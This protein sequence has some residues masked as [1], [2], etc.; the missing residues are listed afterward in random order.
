LFINHPDSLYN[1][2][3]IENP[4]IGAK[5]FH[6]LEYNSPTNDL[7]PAKKDPSA[8]RVFVMGSSTVVGFP[9]ESNLMFPR[10]LQK[11]LQEA[12]PAK[13][14]EVIN[15]AITAINSFTLQDFIDDILD[16]KPDAILIYAGHNEYYGAMG[17]GSNEG[18]GSNRG[19]IKL[20]LKLMDFR[21][22]QLIR[23]TIGKFTKADVI[24]GENK[25][26]TLMSRIVRNAEIAYGSDDYS[27]GLK[28]YKKNMTSILEKASDKK[29]PVFIST[30]VSNITDIKPFGSV[31]SETGES[32]EDIYFRAQSAR[33]Q[34]D[35]KLAKE[36][37]TRAK[38]LDCVRFRASS[39]INTAIEEMAQK[40][41]AILVPMLKAFEDKSPN[42][43]V[44]NNLLTE[45]VHPNVSGYFLMADVFYK[46][47]AESKLI[48][49]EPDRLTSHS[50][51]AFRKAYGF[52]HLDSLIGHHR[53][54]N[55][56]Y[57]WPYKDDSKNY[58]DYR[59]VYRPRNIMDSLAFS[60]MADKNLSGLE[61]HIT[62]ARKHIAQSWLLGAYHEYKAIV[63]IAPSSPE[64]LREAGS[65]F[66]T[67][68]DL[69]LA[70]ECFNKSLEFEDSYFA[71]F[72]AGEICLIQN[73][74]EKAV[75]YFIKASKTAD[76]D[77][78]TKILTKL[79]YAY[80]YQGKR[81]EAGVVYKAIKTI[82]PNLDIPVLAKSYIF[83]T[84]I[85]IP[86]IDDVKN[87]IELLNSNKTEEALS[88]L[89]T[90]LETND[91]PAVCRMVGEIYAQQKQFEKAFFYLDKAYPWFKYEPDFLILQARSNIAGGRNSE[92]KEC[93]EQLKKI[94]PQNTAIGELER[95]LR[96]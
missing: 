83:G 67:A 79:F 88:I 82:N 80:V 4:E 44:G 66:I 84:F 17:V 22:Y 94:E 21:F 40:E 39:D 50:E 18:I 63:Q 6:H 38:D 60:V 3:K 68:C 9:Y 72:R 25:P 28:M 96:D 57:H 27:A 2:Y 95:G 15:T 69:P 30:L 91:S 45:H 26:R 42:S 86:I 47:I 89:L 14:I 55:L 33:Q 56:K 49:N 8:F 54:E 5:Y 36:L 65:L 24:S 29:V 11:R 52:S 48:G 71:N 51:A 61:A 62:L 19:L 46:S 58:V 90:C 37:F 75:Q 12:Y 64:L 34:G 59:A 70:L 20:H 32:A 23:N 10:I 13:K 53:I 31:K 93:L 74:T 73:N 81:D 1:G 35:Y 43:L 92:A 76:R 85:P 77:Y 87:S 41:G 7:F 78:K 16:E